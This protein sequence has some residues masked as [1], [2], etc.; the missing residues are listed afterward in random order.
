MP[1]FSESS[2]SP[3]DS[4]LRER[5]DAE[6]EADVV[7]SKH[8]TSPM[9]V[10]RR[11]AVSRRFRMPRLRSIA[12]QN[13]GATEEAPRDD[14]RAPLGQQ[15]PT[16]PHGTDT[17]INHRN[18]Q[19]TAPHQQ[20]SPA[21]STQ[22]LVHTQGTSGERTVVARSHEV[23]LRGGGCMIVAHTFGGAGCQ[24]EVV[25]APATPVRGLLSDNIH[26][27]ASDWP[28]AAGWGGLI[29]HVGGA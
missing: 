28:N 5:F 19:K 13:K 8:Q 10:K 7:Q 4:F 22:H 17:T 21:P 26:S 15:K 3:K 9:R 23:A 18:S 16:S 1:N 6:G 14:S 20:H 2:V 11:T 12:I 24:Q 25:R 27:P 29:R